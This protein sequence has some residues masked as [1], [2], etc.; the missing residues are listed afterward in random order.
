MYFQKKKCIVLCFKFSL[1]KKRNC[2]FVSFD[3]ICFFFKS[4]I[5]FFFLKPKNLFFFQCM[6][7]ILF[8]HFVFVFYA[9]VVTDPE[10]KDVVELSAFTPDKVTLYCDDGLNPVRTNEVCVA[11]N[12]SV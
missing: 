12:E 4:Y 2:V 11:A 8:F 3:F 5:V 1:K 7:L 6:I 10:N 9:V